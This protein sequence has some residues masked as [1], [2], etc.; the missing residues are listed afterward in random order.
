[1]HCYC[2]RRILGGDV[3][4]AAVAVASVPNVPIEHTHSKNK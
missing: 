3:V 2:Y 1:M 4:V